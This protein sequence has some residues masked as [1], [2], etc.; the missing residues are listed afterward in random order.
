MVTT[1]RTSTIHLTDAG[2]Q[3]IGDADM[4]EGL[5]TVEQYLRLTERTNRLFEYNKGSIE[6]L[7]MPTDEHQD[8]S[9]FLYTA[10]RAYMV[11]IGGKVLFSP[12]PLQINEEQFREPDLLLVL[13]ANDPRR[14]NTFWLGADMVVEIVSPSNRQLDTKVKRA[15]YAHIGIPEYWIVD[16]KKSTITVLSLEGEA[17]AEHGVFKRGET[18]TSVLLEDFTVDVNATFDAR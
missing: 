5:W 2:G 17:Y 6:V 3:T 8:I 1:V 12:M 18:V 10:L 4:F 11:K 9:G 14:Q 7:P 16:P 15:E 13:D